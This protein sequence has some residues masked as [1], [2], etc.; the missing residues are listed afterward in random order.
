M[1]KPV[2]D[3]SREELEQKVDSLD[4]FPGNLAEYNTFKGR[5]YEI[6]DTGR[7]EK[8][9]VFNEVF[10]NMATEETK[11]MKELIRDGCEALIYYSLNNDV[12]AYREQYGIPVKKIN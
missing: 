11:L 8:Y 6:M 10:S 9:V 5:E 4:L 3:L 12:I 1:D 2:K 7:Q